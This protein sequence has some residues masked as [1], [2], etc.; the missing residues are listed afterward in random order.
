MEV[1]QINQRLSVI[2]NFRLVWCILFVGMKVKVRVLH[3][4]F[5]TNTFTFDKLYSNPNLKAGLLQVME[6]FYLQ[7]FCNSSFNKWTVTSLLKGKGLGQAVQMN[8]S[9][10]KVPIRISAQ[11]SVCVCVCVCVSNVQGLSISTFMV[12]KQNTTLL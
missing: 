11:T 12:S 9:Q 5:R 1:K 4:I 3:A 7:Y 10:C 2:W 6:H 8:G